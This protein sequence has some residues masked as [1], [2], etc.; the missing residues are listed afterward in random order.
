MIMSGNK[1]EI[2]R[3]YKVI[4]SNEFIQKSRFKLSMPE[5]KVIWYIIS[6]IKF[7]DE[8]FKWYEFNLNEF[9]RLC[10]IG[11]KG[12][13][14]KTIKAALLSL[15]SKN[16]WVELIPGEVTTMSWIDKAT[17]IKGNG[18]VRIRLDEDMMPYLLRIKEEY[19]T[20][21]LSV[22]MAMNGKYEIRLYEIL[23]C[24][25]G[26]G[27][28]RYE[29]NDLKRQMDVKIDKRYSDFNK[30]ILAPAVEINNQYADFIATYVPIKVDSRAYTHVDFTF[31]S[32]T[33]W[34]NYEAVT[35]IEKRLTPVEKQLT[36]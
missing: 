30:D 21:D 32:K 4:K 19:T 18:M 15:A 5:Q 14:Y 36:F 20:L 6:K 16:M 3:N 33:M 13:N 25:A 1:L 24:R 7:E 23:K 22:A 12:D 27:K 28:W 17:I 35:L 8:D 29:L 2:K 10:N 26:N 31:E 11:T 34:Q 9:C